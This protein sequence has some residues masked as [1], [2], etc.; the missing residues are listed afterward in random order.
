MTPKVMT[1]LFLLAWISAAIV[2]DIWVFAKFGAEPTITRTLQ[3]WTSDFP[4]LLIALG[5][6]LWHLFGKGK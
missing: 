1:Q 3:R 6:L 5:G 4:V 2:Y